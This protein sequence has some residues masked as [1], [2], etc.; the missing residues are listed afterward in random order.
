MPPYIFRIQNIS[1]SYPDG[2]P[3]FKD[4]DL[5]IKKGTLT[6]ISGESGAGKSTFLKLFNRFN[7]LTDGKILY[8]ERELKDYQINEIRRSNL[9]LS[10]LP[11]VIE[12]SIKDNLSFPFSFQAHKDKRYSSD[13]A[14]EWLDYFHLGISLGHEALKLSIG[15]RQRIALIRALLLEPE[16]LL[17]DEPCSA[18]DS[19]N[20][21]LIEQKIESLME[22]A[23]ITVIMATHSEVNFSES[24][25]SSFRLGD[26]RLKTL[27][28]N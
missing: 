24:V 25:Y 16:V 15:Q 22:S 13:R 1:F 10:Q 11:H 6:V 12:G 4:I 17:L 21:R 2:K 18:L 5:T 19:R 27:K 26:R 9:Y 23:G 3:V 14:R 8:H 20:R 28:S 7:E